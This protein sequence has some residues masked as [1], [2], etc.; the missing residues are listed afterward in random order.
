LK[1]TNCTTLANAQNWGVTRGQ[2]RNLL[3]LQS[4]DVQVI[5]T[6]CNG[7]ANMAQ[8]TVNARYNVGAVPFLNASAVQTTLTSVSCFPFSS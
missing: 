5:S 1:A 4:G 2:T 3:S 7:V 6:T 8:A